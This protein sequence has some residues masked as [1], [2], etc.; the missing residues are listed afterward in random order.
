[1]HLIHYQSYLLRLW[2]DEYDAVCQ[3]T[4]QSTTTEEILQF[5]SLELLFSF[6]SP[7]QDKPVYGE[8]ADKGSQQSP[9]RC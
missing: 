9:P 5:A 3:V 8:S 1:M 4:L 6:L 7:P 2:R